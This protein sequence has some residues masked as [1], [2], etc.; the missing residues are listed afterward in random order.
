MVAV[1]LSER[2]FSESY[3]GNEPLRTLIGLIPFSTTGRCFSRNVPDV[4]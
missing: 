4:R 3:S 1:P 2:L